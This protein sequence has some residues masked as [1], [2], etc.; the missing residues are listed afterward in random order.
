MCLITKNPIQ[1][2]ETD[3]TVFKALT[4]HGDSLKAPFQDFTYKK[5]ELYK[6]N[7]EPSHEWVVVDF[8]S[9]YHLYHELKAL[10]ILY[11]S[12]LIMY[13]TELTENGYKCYGQ[14]FHS[15]SNKNRCDEFCKPKYINSVPV[16]CTIPAGSEYII[17]ETGCVISNQIIINEVLL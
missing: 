13:A 8:T 9:F 2:A 1:I 16:R 10:G 3:I 5:G 17:D 4:V 6:T 14:G 15:F 7:I 12:N 11:E